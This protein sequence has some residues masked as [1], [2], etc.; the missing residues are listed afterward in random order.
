MTIECRVDVLRNNAVF[1]QLSIV[2]TPQVNV[3]NQQ[4]IQRELSVSHLDDAEINLLTDR[5]AAY[6]ILDGKEYPL[7]K[8]VAAEAPKS[9]GNMSVRS[10]TAYGLVYLTD[11]L[12]KIEERLHI[13]AGTKYTDAIQNQLILSGIVDFFIEPSDAVIS[14][15]REDWEPGEKRSTILHQLCSEINYL[16]PYD[17]NNGLVQVRAFVRPTIENVNFSYRVDNKSILYQDDTQDT[18][19][20]ARPNV[21]MLICENPEKETDGTE[22]L[23]ATSVNTDPSSPISVPN[24]GRRILHIER[25]DNIAS[26]EELQHK[27]DNMMFGN[28]TITENIGISTGPNPAHDCFNILAV[29]KGSIKGIYQEQAWTLDLAGSGK[30]AHNL[31]GVVLV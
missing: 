5:F 13:P 26:L 6:M 7:G 25:V 4:V 16:P 14:E 29:D 8:F 12:A 19:M 30:M 23:V 20:F 10:L 18:D 24:V 27:A 15:D 31:K 28:L 11:E 2:G 21:F 9:N 22:E 1:K 17:D 3:N